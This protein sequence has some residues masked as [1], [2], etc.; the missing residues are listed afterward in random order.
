MQI[1]V[2]L[3]RSIENKR[4]FVIDSDEVT[5]AALQFMLHDENE[6]HELSSVPEAVTKCAGRKVD[7]VLL[8]RAIVAQEGLGVLQEITDHMPE[9]KVVL[10]ADST[11]DARECQQWS[12]A[13]VLTKPLTVESVRL[14]VDAVLGRA[15]G[16]NPFKVL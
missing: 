10:V 11:E 7:L 3:S 15:P 6:T 16:F 9:A 13:G 1:G 5:R 4:V 14:K 12:T 8:G 2:E